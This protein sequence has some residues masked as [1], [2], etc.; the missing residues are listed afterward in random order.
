ME[1]DT[2]FRPSRHGFAFANSWRDVLFG[3]IVLRGRCGGMVFA[4][5][6]Y[7]TPGKE[8]PAAALEKTLPARDSALAR[9]IWRRQI[10]SAIGH[11]G[12]NLRRFAQYT[13]LP[14]SAVGG[15]S[16]ATLRDSLVLFDGLRAGAPVPLGLVSAVGLTQLPRNHQVLAYAADFAEERVLVRAYDPNYPRRDD[17]TLVVPLRKG[18]PV[19]EHIG[20]SIKVWRGMFVEHRS[21][22]WGKLPG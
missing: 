15:I 22:P 19:V 3:V 2:E 21:R 20:V 16:E 6:D 14:S 18:S 1:F 7:F 5:Q 13:Y 11:V 12:E 8:L 10:A 17:V 4:A 9:F